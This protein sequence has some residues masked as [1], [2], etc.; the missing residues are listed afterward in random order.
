MAS[1]PTDL[2]AEQYRWARRVVSTL[3][4]LDWTTL[5]QGPRP[6]LCLDGAKSDSIEKDVLEIT[7]AFEYRWIWRDTAR[8]YRNPGYRR[9]SLLVPLNETL[10]AH[11]LVH[12]LRQQIGFILLGEEDNGNLIAH[13]KQ[14]H[15]LTG[16]DGF[17]VNFSLNGARALEEVCE[18]LTTHS[19]SR[20]FGPIQRMI[21]YAGNEH[22]GEWLVAD[23]P[24]IGLAM[25]ILDEPIALTKADEASLDHASLAWFVRDCV[26]NI[27]QQT[28]AHHDPNNEP[29]LWRRV[30]LFIREAADQLA[31]T[32]E[33]DVRHYV[34][35]R[36]C[37]PQDFFAKDNVL[38]EILTSRLIQGKQRL[39]DAEARLATLAAR[40]RKPIT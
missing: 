3:P 36:I 28:P 26:R 17:P 15:Q 20:M 39:V 38:R 13:L 2:A 24:G 23:S 29:V 8:E 30:D 9:G 16:T 25:P 14:L 34:D 18:G 19:L 11:A 6:W 27:R 7:G 32:L 33:R 31:L 1:E 4:R 22:Q 40:Q 12:W 35:L 10:F 21:W 37:Y 5:E